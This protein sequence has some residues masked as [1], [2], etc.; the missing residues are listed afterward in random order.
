[1]GQV[2]G[3]LPDIR[4]LGNGL[5]VVHGDVEPSLDDGTAFTDASPGQSVV[6][7]FTIENT[8]D[9]A[10]EFVGDPPIV[11]AGA[12]P[13]DFSI[14]LQPTLSLEP[15]QHHTFEVQFNPTT[16]GVRLATVFDW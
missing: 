10:L 16:F 8:G 7:T 3:P 14:S 9:A 15:G 2:P 4:V 12:N 1:M 5:T 11:I 13:D 6:H